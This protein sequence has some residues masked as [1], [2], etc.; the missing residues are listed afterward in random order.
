MYIHRYSKVADFFFNASRTEK[1]RII[2]TFRILRKRKKKSRCCR[3]CNDYKLQYYK[4]NITNVLQYF[5]VVFDFLFRFFYLG[6]LWEEFAFIA[7]AIARSR[8]L[9]PYT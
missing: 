1:E 8:F 3:K 7:C 5:L 6:P 9:F 2:I 4:Y